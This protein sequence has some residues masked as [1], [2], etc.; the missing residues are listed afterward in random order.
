MINKVTLIGNTGQ[1]PDIRTLENGTQ[2]ARFSVATNESYKDKDGNWQTQ[3]EW[4]NVIA[5]REL[6]ERASKSLKKGVLIYIEGKIQYR[7]F[8][9]KDGIERTV[10]D[11]VCSTFRL[12]EKQG[13]TT[14]EQYK[15]QSTEPQSTE[16]QENKQKPPAAT[17]D[18]LP[19]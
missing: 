1:D 12:L 5:W 9:D 13:G 3:T 17:G 2:V 7:K 10:T 18:D 4:H 16:P 11:I 6:S 15:P 19:F 14:Q 8:T